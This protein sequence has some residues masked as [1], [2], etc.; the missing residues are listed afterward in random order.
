MDLNVILLAGGLGK[1]MN[2]TLPKVLH[3]VQ[4]EPMLVKVIRQCLLLQPSHIFVV[5]GKFKHSICD[6]MNQYLT[7]DQM[8]LVE[9]VLQVPALGTG[10]AVQQCVPNLSKCEPTSST[11]I[12]SGD[13]PL[14]TFDTLSQ[15]TIGQTDCRLLVTRFADPFGYGRIIR[16]ANG[17]FVKIVEQKDCSTEEAKVD[18]CNSGIYLFNTGLLCSYVNQLTNNNAQKE[19]YIT[20]LP[21]ILINELPYMNVDLLVLPTDRQ[22]ELRGV[23]TEAQLKELNRQLNIF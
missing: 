12:V 17:E 15:F 3:E 13:T 6:T 21:E 23:N 16:D 11:L 22:I 10:H 14:I 4:G 2:S 8:N 7:S 9:F 5:V 18:L 19:Y 1:R 20:D